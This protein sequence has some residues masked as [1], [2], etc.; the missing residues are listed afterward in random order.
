LPFPTPAIIFLEH[1]EATGVHFSGN[2]C[3]FRELRRR[4]PYPK[5]SK[6]PIAL[7]QIIKKSASTRAKQKQGLCLFGLFLVEE[8]YDILVA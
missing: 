2:T 5:S 4:S 1:T 3:I 6:L 8:I 7:S